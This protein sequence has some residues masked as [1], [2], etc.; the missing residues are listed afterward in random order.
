MVF[1]HFLTRI[2][3]TTKISVSGVGGFSR[4]SGRFTFST[5]IDEMVKILQMVIDGDSI[6]TN[7]HPKLC[8]AAGTGL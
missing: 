7:I 1:V 5:I 3:T 6:G 8:L 4:K 2:S